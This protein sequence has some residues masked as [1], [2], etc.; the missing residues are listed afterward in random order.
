MTVLPCVAKLPRLMQT[1]P[2]QFFDPA[3]LAESREEISGVLDINGMQ[4][5]HG[6]LC[7]DAASIQFELH[8]D[9]DE[10]NRIRISGRYSTSLSMECRRCLQPVG[11][12]IAGSVNVVLLAS[13]DEVAELP[14][15]L[16]P[17]IMTGRKLSL[18]RFFEDELLLALPLAPSHNTDVCHPQAPPPDRDNGD[19]RR[20]FAILKDLKLKNS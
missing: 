7:N 2:P 13:E 1:G 18:H 9:K 12:D 20:P 6:L 5:L 4:G 15:K 10:Q 8:F 17:L 14:R 16:E 3:R 19:G 11:V